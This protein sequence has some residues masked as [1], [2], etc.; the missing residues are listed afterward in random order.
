MSPTFHAWLQ[1]ELER[2]Q[3]RQQDLADAAGVSQQTASRWL[4]GR[5]TPTARSIRELAGALGLTT[6]EV[7]A[8]LE[9]P[10]S[11]RADRAEG[12]ADLDAELRALRLRVR[13]LEAQLTRRRQ[14]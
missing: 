3:W 7:L 13:Q 4:L 8:H 9:S 14:A 5:T 11:S 6:D 1:G 2:R 10:P 12:T